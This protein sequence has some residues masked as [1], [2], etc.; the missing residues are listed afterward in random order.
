[1]SLDNKTLSTKLKNI[2]L[3]SK[4]DN[5]KRVIILQNEDSPMEILSF[6][7]EALQSLGATLYVIT[8]DPLRGSYTLSSE[9]HL[10]NHDV[11]SNNSPEDL[12]G[13]AD[14]VFETIDLAKLS[15]QNENIESLSLINK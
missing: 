4:V 3:L 7:V 8:H 10:N 1:M 15:A 9:Y 12:L 11:I 14:I 13:L 6:A 5:T 2:F